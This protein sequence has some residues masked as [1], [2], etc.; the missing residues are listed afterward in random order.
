VDHLGGGGGG[1]CVWLAQ[2][3]AGLVLL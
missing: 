2:A 1:A 3:A